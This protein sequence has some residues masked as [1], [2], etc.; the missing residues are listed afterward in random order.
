MVRVKLWLEVTAVCTL[1]VLLVVSCIPVASP[2]PPPSPATPPVSEEQAESTPATGENSEVDIR[3]GKPGSSDKHGEPVLS[4]A[5]I[6]GCKPSRQPGS[7]FETI[8]RLREGEKA[9]DF[10][11]KDI[12]GNEFILSRLLAEKPVLMVFGSF[13]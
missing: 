3:D 6:R 7:G 12:D 11:L 5:L 10:T 1:L 8:G 9:V 13:T 2:S 4:N